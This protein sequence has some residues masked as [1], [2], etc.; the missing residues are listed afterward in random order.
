MSGPGRMRRRFLTGVVVL[1]GLF[2]G[3]A[4]IAVPAFATDGPEQLLSVADS[5]KTSDHTRFIQLL[6]QLSH[7]AASL[8]PTQQWHLRYLVAWQVAYGGDYDTAGP[9][10]TAVIEQPV[11]VTLRLR[12]TATMVNILGIGHRYD[13]AFIRLNQLLDQL[14]AVTEKKARA[15]GLGEASQMLVNAGQYELAGSYAE[16]MLSELSPGESNCKAEYF[17]LHARFRGGKMQSLDPA[18]QDGVDSCVKTGE[19]LFANAVR[20]D[21]AAFDIQ[22]GRA[23]EAIALLQGNYADVQHDQY[24]SQTSLFEALLAQ[25]YWKTGN[26]AR[27]QS[28]ASAAVGTSIK[29][30]YTEPLSMAYETLYRIADQQGDFRDALAYHKKFMEADKGYLNDVSAKVL[31]YQIVKQQMQAKKVQLDAL[32]RQNQI[33]QL[34]QALDR[35]AVE[36]GRLYIVLLLTVLASIALWL[37]RLKRSQLRFMQLARRDGLT[38]I[39]NRQHFVD[40]AEQALRYAA[41]SARGACLILIDLDHF[42]LVNDTHGHAVGDQVLKRAVAACRL[43][44]NSCDVF[45]RLGGEEFGI[46]LPECGPAQALDRAEKIRM[47]IA[48]T[49]VGSEVDDVAISASFGVASTNHCGYALHRLLMDADNALYQAKRDGRDRVVSARANDRYASSH[50]YAEPAT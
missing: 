2:A 21:M 18:F 31:A 24:P 12:A 34:E 9:L 15:Q 47:A 4:S 39:C 42:K 22:Q 41:K 44:L 27:A 29:G 49:P 50:P 16:R 48:E 26:V 46:L 25:A 38:G 32:N 8:S 33:L 37:Y 20:A 7:D 45:G 13:E 40:E 17:W 3:V 43:H 10:L 30:E 23:G 11:D 6:D 5:V 19:K 1:L 36:A 28:F 14:P 35:K